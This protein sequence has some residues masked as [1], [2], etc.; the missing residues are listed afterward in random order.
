MKSFLSISDLIPLPPC[1]TPLSSTPVRTTK[2]EHNPGANTT[3]KND[4]HAN[5]N[6]KSYLPKTGLPPPPLSAIAAFPCHPFEKHG[7]H[8]PAAAAAAR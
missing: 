3:S 8:P 1:F 5:P 6:P 2:A 4:P 7:S